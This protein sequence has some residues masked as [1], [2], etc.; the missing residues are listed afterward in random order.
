MRNRLVFAGAV[1]ARRNAAPMGETVGASIRT[2]KVIESPGAMVALFTLLPGSTSR[3]TICELAAAGMTAN[4]AAHAMNIH[5]HNRRAFLKVDPACT[6]EAHSQRFVATKASGLDAHIS[7]IGSAA[8]SSRYVAQ[9]SR[10]PHR[11]DR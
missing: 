3:V 9:P 4:I 11:H 8:R 6:R 1:C 10:L 2:S 5:S 7:M